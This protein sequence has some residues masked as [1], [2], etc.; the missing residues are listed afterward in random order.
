MFFDHRPERAS[1]QFRVIKWSVIRVITMW[2]LHYKWYAV[3]TPWTIKN[4]RK[5]WRR[6]VVKTRHGIMDGS[7]QARALGAVNARLSPQAHDMQLRFRIRNTWHKLH[8]V[9]I[10]YILQ[11][12]TEIALSITDVCTY[13]ILTIVD[14]LSCTVYK[15]SN[16]QWHCDQI[17]V[18]RFLFYRFLRNLNLWYVI[19]VTYALCSVHRSLC[20]SDLQ[21]GDKHIRISLFAYRD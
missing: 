21:N 6:S 18:T 17:F 2:K 19:T 10:L 3:I 8:M 9:G 14:L 5:K 13:L 20:T 12:F 4:A 1:Q 15:I 16:I 7:P 11:T